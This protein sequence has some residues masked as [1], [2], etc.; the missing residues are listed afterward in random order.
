M[1]VETEA[2]I[3]MQR[4]LGRD[5]GVA[6]GR[7]GGAAVAAALEIGAANPGAV[8]VTILPDA[9]EPTSEEPER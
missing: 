6:V 1:R 8:V 9:A 4:R 5:E 7:S 3:E 2:A